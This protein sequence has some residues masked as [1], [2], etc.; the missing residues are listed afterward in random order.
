MTEGARKRDYG[1]WKD[2]QRDEQGNL[3]ILTEEER[4]RRRSDAFAALEGKVQ[5]KTQ[6]KTDADRIS[7]LKA[8]RN[9]SWADPYTQNQKL[10]A[11][12]RPGRKLRQQNQAETEQLQQRLGLGIDLL[13]ETEE[14]AKRASFVEFGDFADSEE[15]ATQA[16]RKPLFQAT[17]NKPTHKLGS[18]KGRHEKPKASSLLAATLQSNTRATT[19]PFLVDRG[20]SFPET[21]TGHVIPGLKRKRPSTEDEAVPRKHVDSPDTNYLKDTNNSIGISAIGKQATSLVAYDSDND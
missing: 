8:Y 15:T 17:N 6:A 7:A 18:L 3:K 1:E 9:K 11:L 14:D 16:A 21:S 20:R 5:D 19:D 4:E 10:R 12:F 13:E 2:E